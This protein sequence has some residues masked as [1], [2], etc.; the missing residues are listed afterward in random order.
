[1]ASFPKARSYI[2]AAALDNS[3]FVF[4]ENNHF[5]FKLIF[6]DSPGGYDGKHRDEIFRYNSI[7]DTWTE[8]GKMTTPRDDFSV[9]PRVLSDCCS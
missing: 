2:S 3:V 5:Y 9:A 1:M 6:C 7:N 8:A 4:G